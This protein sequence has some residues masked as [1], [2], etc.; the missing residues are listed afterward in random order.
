MTRYKFELVCR[1]KNCSHE[2]NRECAKI[3]THG[4]K[5][6]GYLPVRK[7]E[8]KTVKCE[9]PDKKLKFLGGYPIGKLAFLCEC[10]T[11][12]HKPWNYEIEKHRV[13]SSEQKVSE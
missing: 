5:N 4:C 3:G 13:Q 2:L 8:N 10:G 7:S 6:L 12:V 9:H 11:I 1:N